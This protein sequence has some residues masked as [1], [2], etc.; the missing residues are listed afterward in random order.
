MRREARS[1]I[2]RD[3]D[4]I[5]GIVKERTKNMIL[6]KHIKRIQKGVKFLFADAVGDDCIDRYNW[7][8]E[9]AHVMR[10]LGSAVAKRRDLYVLRL[11]E[12]PL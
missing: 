7:E 9:H 11:V 8:Y 1:R 4:R 3:Y 2:E 10:D 6:S 12:D 5:W